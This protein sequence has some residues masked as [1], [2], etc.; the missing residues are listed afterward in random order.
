MRIQVGPTANRYAPET[1]TESN[2]VNQKLSNI[3]YDNFTFLFKLYHEKKT[4]K[5]RLQECF[6]TLK[7]GKI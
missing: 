2:E 7:S 4:Q 6:E 3:S 1:P 5:G